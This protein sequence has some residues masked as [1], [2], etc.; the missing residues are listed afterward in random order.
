MN[1]IKKINKRANFKFIYYVIAISLSFWFGQGTLGPLGVFFSWGSALLFSVLRLLEIL[2]P[3]AHV[4]H[5]LDS[6]YKV[7]LLII[8]L[9]LLFFFTI[10]FTISISFIN[11]K[12]SKKFRSPIPYLTLV[13]Y[14]SG[15]L[16]A[17]FVMP[18]YEGEYWNNTWSYYLFPIFIIFALLYI[19]IE[20]QAAKKMKLSD[21]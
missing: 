13:Y 18:S 5:N 10:I 9:G 15:V 8:L 16:A 14:V 3:S 17:F 11:T 12:L 7:L 6:W 1:D 4:R 20:W 2:D 21:S 19:I